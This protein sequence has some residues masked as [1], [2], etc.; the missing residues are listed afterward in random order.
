MCGDTV[1]KDSDGSQGSN[2]ML[3]AL[4]AMCKALGSVP[5]AI[6]KKPPKWLAVHFVLIGPSRS[7]GPL[8]KNKAVT[9]RT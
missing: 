7:M 8:I 5:S 9:Q 4:F 1:R 2:S 3:E 6:F